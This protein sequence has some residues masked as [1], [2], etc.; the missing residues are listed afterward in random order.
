MRACFTCQG[1]FEDR[2]LVCP[3]DGDMLIDEGRPAPETGWT[4][5]AWRLGN[6]LGEG[7]MGRVFEAA[8]L[9]S[10]EVVAV[11]VLKEGPSGV[12]QARKRFQMEAEAAAALQHPGVARVREL[13]RTAE[14]TSYIVME[15]LH[16]STFDELRRAGKFAEAERV[17]ELMLEIC[18]VLALAHE[19]GIVHRDLKPSN[20][21]LHRERR[22]LSRVKVLDFGIAKFLDRPGD[23]L[24]STGDFLG[25]LL[26]MAPEQTASEAVTTA[27]DVYSL[28]VILFEALTGALPFTGRSPLE[29]LR[30]H[31]SMPAPAL[32]TFRPE[33]SL[34]LESLVERCL[35]KKP[36]HRYAGAREL[37]LALRG[38]PLT[39]KEGHPVQAARTSQMNA[40]HWVGTLLDERYEIQEWIAP[41]RF[42]S[43]VY[44][45]SHLHTGA[46]VAVRLWRTGQGSARDSL[47][48]VF[49]REARAM[50]VRHPNLISIIDLGFDDRCVYVVTEL[51]DSI[52][53]RTLLARKG[54]LPED[55]AAALARGAAGALRALHDKGIISGGLSPETMR[56]A[57]GEAGPEKL[58]LTPLGLSDLKQLNLLAGDAARSD[59]ALDYIAPEQRAGARPD[60]RSDLYSLGVIL[61]E[62]LCGPPAG[63]AEPDA[64]PPGAEPASGIRPV[65]EGRAEDLGRWMEFFR[66]ALAPQ[67]DARY[68]SAAEFLAAI[69][70]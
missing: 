52:S 64:G 53:L 23:R 13:A 42:G 29:L 15:R 25:S 18:E 11:K 39:R 50:A 6:L 33:V 56:V 63:P 47:I 21:F 46:D 3:T 48:D 69:P 36:Q 5:G 9:V 38:I 41:S 55:E 32:S 30:L 14:G 68:A 43:D 17:I 12:E 62:M 4:L 22:D 24:T 49:R 2:R 27:V 70:A 20:I 65:P 61:L 31:A 45:A 59:R 10:G 60:A 34:E 57:M 19:K 44:R 16:G 58:L 26:Y 66:R 7:G 40:A 54:K 8:H 28:G 51:V 35:M 37:G 1:R 67:P